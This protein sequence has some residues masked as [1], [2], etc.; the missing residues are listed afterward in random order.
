MGELGVGV[1]L[2]G[3][4]DILFPDGFRCG[5]RGGSS[6]GDGGETLLLPA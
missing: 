3:W 2:R 4:I 1:G 6:E 5:G